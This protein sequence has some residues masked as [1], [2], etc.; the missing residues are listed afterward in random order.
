MSLPPGV[1]LDVIDPTPQL[2]D[3]V[4]EADLVISASGTSS[5][6]LLCLGA[7]CAMV[8]VADNQVTAY[9]RMVATGAVVGLGRLDEIRGD[10]RAASGELRQL[11]TDGRLRD[12]L[13]RTGWRLVDGSGKER[14]VDV[15]TRLGATRGQSPS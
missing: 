5:W 14:V 1:H 9:E 4:L 6:E 13:R 7:A 10:P 11:L 12:R 8:C 2:P 3:R 15:V